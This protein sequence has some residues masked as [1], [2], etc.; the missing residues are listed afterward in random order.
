VAPSTKTIV[1]IR[2]L[3]PLVGVDLPPFVDDSHPKINFFL[4]RKAFISIL[5]RFPC[6]SSNDASCT[7]YELLQDYFVFYDFVSGFVSFLRHVSTLFVV[8]FFH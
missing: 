8:I 2:H 5:T 7:V 1:S 4:D 6:L 3:H